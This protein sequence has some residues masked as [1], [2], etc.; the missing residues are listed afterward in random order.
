MLTEKRFDVVV[1]GN[2]GIDTNVYLPGR[3]IDFSVEAN[4]TENLD[5]V[6]QAG[7]YASR[8][9]AQLGHRTAF[10]GYL[11]H[12]FSGRFIRKT[13][14]RDGIDTTA[15]FIDPLGT[16]RSINFMYS[17]GRRKNF[18]DGKGHMQLEPDLDVCRAV[19][20]QAKLAHFN[21]PNWARRLLPIARE[22]G[23]TIAVDIQDVVTIDDPYRQDFVDV[24]DVLF[25]SATNHPDPT[26]LIE[27]FLQRKPEQIVIVGRGAD[28]CALGTQAGIRLFPA[29]EI[30]RPVIDTNGAGDGLAVGFLSSY[31]LDDYSL[32]DSIRRGQLTARYTCTLKATSSNLMTPEKLAEYFWGQDS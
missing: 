18:Y 15:L 6:G 13:F 26:P 4:F 8:G 27:M 3:E 28:G 10:I 9:Y 31:I 19:L 7:G 17:D 12:D 1:V 11:G 20:A 2:V 22:L 21:I 14:S 16:S 29:E 5:Y 25:L 24:A 23:L 30:D 32:T